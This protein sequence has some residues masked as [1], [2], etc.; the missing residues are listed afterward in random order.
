M[1]KLAIV[2]THPIQYNSPWF[3]LLTRRGKIALKV[4]YTWSQTEQGPKYD[5]DFKKV[6]EWDIPLLDGYEY[7][8]VPNVSQEPGSH[9]FKGIDNPSLNKT[10]A[11]WKPDAILIIGWSFK[12]HLAC[13]RYFKGKVPVLFRGDSTLLDERRGIK[14][15]LRRFFLTWVYR[16]I[17]KALYAGTNNKAYFKAHGVK[18]KQLLLAFHAIDND[19]FSIPSP[20]QNEAV[21]NLRRSLS[22]NDDH[23]VVLFAGKLEEKKNP[24]FLLDLAKKITDP[25]FIFLFTGNGPL[26][27]ALKAKAAGDKRIKFLP[28]QNQSLMPA[29]YALG[30]VF[31]LPSNGPGETWGLGANEAMAAGLPVVLSAKVGGAVDLIRNNGL[32]FPPGKTSEVVRYLTELKA[33]PR[34]LA[35]AKAFSLQRIKKFSYAQL[36]EAVEKGCGL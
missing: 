5:P 32:L 19:R 14:T 28:F 11:A 26:E 17:D 13:M 29:V 2:C 36:A 24:F 1:K 9:H 25:D 7:T 31:M 4:F 15:F 16:N 22:I 34:E 35:M 27:E 12:S 18:E 8:F 30:S 3:Q 21:N 20:A 33:S 10:I 6:V 23:F